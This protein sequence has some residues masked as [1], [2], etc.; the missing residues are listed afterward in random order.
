MH[1]GDK[2]CTGTGTLISPWHVLTTGRNLYDPRTKTWAQNIQFH[3]GRNGDTLLHNSVSC[4]K[5]AVFPQWQ[6]GDEKSDMGII[7][8][9]ESIGHQLGWNGLL[10]GDDSF[11]SKV[12]PVNVTGYP[13]EKPMGTMWT[14]FSKDWI[15]VCESQIA[16][17]LSASEG[18]NGASVWVRNPANGPEGFYSV[19]VHA[20]GVSWNDAGV[21]NIATRLTQDKFLAIINCINEKF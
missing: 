17:S 8:L 2:I 16:Y 20:Y 6:G 1:F 13:G 5:K 14:D 12:D 11:L 21:M 10:W 3:P 9:S 15:K 19:G 18:Q 7:E 4:S